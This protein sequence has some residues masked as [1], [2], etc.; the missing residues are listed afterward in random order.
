MNCIL[1]IKLFV[2]LIFVAQTH[3]THA[4]EKDFLDHFIKQEQELIK[5][6]SKSSQEGKKT[7]KYLIATA[8]KD[9]LLYYQV[10]A[11]NEAYYNYDLKLGLNQIKTLK[12]LIEN[13]KDTYLK[14]YYYIST[15]YLY[16][17]FE[18]TGLYKAN[19]EQAQKFAQDSSQIKTCQALMCKV[20]LQ[21]SMPKNVIEVYEKF[22]KEDLKHEPNQLQF[23]YYMLTQAYLMDGQIKNA[24][25]TVNNWKI[26]FKNQK[27]DSLEIN[28]L[29]NYLYLYEAKCIIEAKKANLL[30]LINEKFR[31]IKKANFIDQNFFLLYHET[32]QKYFEWIKN[33]DSTTFYKLKITK[34]LNQVSQK[35]NTILK[36]IEEEEKL[37][38]YN[39]KKKYI[40][41]ILILAVLIFGS[42]LYFIK[43]L[44]KKNT[45]KLINKDQLID[46]YSSLLI[47]KYNTIN[48]AEIK[49]NELEKEAKDYSFE[50]KI[51]AI[52]ANITPASNELHLIKDLTNKETLIYE[53]LKKQ[54]TNFTETEL[55]IGLLICNEK[56]NISIA[57]SLNISLKAAENHRYRMRKKLNLKVGESLEKALK[58]LF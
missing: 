15:A 37:E 56:T 8:P 30:P 32:K 29:E 26:I 25:E 23:D 4:T 2:I 47:D 46:K 6:F 39:L 54:L 18:N 44:K 12:P 20:Y 33:E 1:R 24:M 53:K 35:N 55:R 50:K 48:K 28:E 52:R 43:I 10:L 41:G 27:K 51:K 40:I 11:M 13:S 36:E 16:D 22:L 38:A 17:A 3:I 57:E 5:A 9:K 14:Y 19:L 31:K 58:D 45:R 34:H 21:M 7:L 42:F 49:L